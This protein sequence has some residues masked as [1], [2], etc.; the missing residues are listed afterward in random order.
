M[1]EAFFCSSP[2]LLSVIVCAVYVRE[3][4]TNDLCVCVRVCVCV[5]TS[6]LQTVCL[7]QPAS[8]WSMCIMLSSFGNSEELLLW[9]HS[10]V[11]HVKSKIVIRPEL[12][13]IYIAE[14]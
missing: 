2:P 10:F 4:V 14:L 3:G 13:N 1:C 8:I 9:K 5:C 11:R 6:E 12:P 7:W